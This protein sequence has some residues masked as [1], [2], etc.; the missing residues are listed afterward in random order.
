METEVQE[1]C[2]TGVVAKIFIE[3]SPALYVVFISDIPRAVSGS[4]V[5]DR[6]K[7]GRVRLV[8]VLALAPTPHQGALIPAGVAENEKVGPV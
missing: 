7:S 4:P 2:L 3:E 1:L 5:G 8:S 6:W